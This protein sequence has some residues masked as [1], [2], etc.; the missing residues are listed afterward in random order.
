MRQARE[1]THWYR[2]EIKVGNSTVWRR[3]GD[4]NYKDVV[5]STQ[6]KRGAQNECGASQCSSTLLLY[7]SSWISRWGGPLPHSQGMRHNKTAYPLIAFAT[8]ARKGAKEWSSF[9]R[10]PE[11]V[12]EIRRAEDC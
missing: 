2:E 8:V 7:G 5:L 10:W 1:A 12:R 6:S 3:H 9:M 4:G 11:L